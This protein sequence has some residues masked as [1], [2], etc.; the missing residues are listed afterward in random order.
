MTW[1]S[2]GITKCGQGL[3]AGELLATC[4]RSI[5]FLMNNNEQVHIQYTNLMNTR[6]TYIMLPLEKN[7]PRVAEL[8][9]H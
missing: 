8:D 6:I 3:R 9:N 1:T 4:E 7:R 5:T 2:L